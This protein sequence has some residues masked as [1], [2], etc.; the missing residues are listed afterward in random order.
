MSGYHLGMV[1]T[2]SGIVVHVGYPDHANSKLV[3]RRFQGFGAVIW[4]IVKH[5]GKANDRP[6]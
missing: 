4:S 6:A 3:T 1:R 2:E 5:C